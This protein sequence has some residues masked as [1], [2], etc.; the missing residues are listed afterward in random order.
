M[1]MTDAEWLHKLGDMPMSWLDGKTV[2]RIAARLEQ[3]EAEVVELRKIKANAVADLI[4][5]DMTGSIGPNPSV[6]CPHEFRFDGYTCGEVRHKLYTCIKCGE[7][8][9]TSAA[10]KPHDDGSIGPEK[11][12]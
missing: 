7:C 11:E 3:L 9:V 8:R 1:S 6:D 5:Q 4:K 12:D 10:L 2:H